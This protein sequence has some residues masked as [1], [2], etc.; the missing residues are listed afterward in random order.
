MTTNYAYDVLD[1]L[2]A[3]CQGGALD[4]NNNCT[5]GQSRQFS[6]DWLKRL[7]SATNP[8]T[9]IST[10]PGGTIQYTQYDGNGNLLAKQDTRMVTT[11]MTYDAM[12]RILTKSY[13]D[14]AT[15][16][17]TYCYDGAVAAAGGGSCTNPQTAIP[18]AL[19]HLTQ[20]YSSASATT[21]NAF[22]GSGRVVL[23]SQQT[24]SVG[25]TLYQFGTSASSNPGYAYNLASQLTTIK[26]PS[27][28]AVAYDYDLAGRTAK[29]RNPVAQGVTY[30]D[31]SLF[32]PVGGQYAYAPHGAIQKMT[33]GSG[34][35]EST[36]WDPVRLQPT[37]VQAGSLLTLQYA[38]CPSGASGCASNNGNLLQQQ[39]TT[40]NLA[41]TQ[42]YQYTDGF[43]QVTSA[44]ETSN[45]TGGTSWSQTYQYDSYGNRAV[46]SGYT[47][48]TILT[49]SA[50]SQYVETIGVSQVNRNHWTGA[51]YDNA[52]NVNAV[53]GS[54][55][56]F[57]Y[58][59][60]N[61]M[62]TS[63]EPNMG[64]ISYVYDGD[65]KR[66]QKTVG[67]AVTSYVYDA[68]EEL[69][70]EY[71]AATDVGTAYLNVDPLGSTRLFLNPAAGETKYFDYF[72]FGEDIQ[73]GI[74]TRGANYPTGAYPGTPDA[75][76]AKF[77]AKE[78]DAETGLDYFGARYFSSAQGRF[79][80][81]DPEIIPNN[82]GNPQAWNKY[83]YTYN[84][85]LRYTDPDGHAP[86][87]GAALIQDRDVKDLL[88]NRITQQEYMDRQNARGAGAIVG[89]G[90][91]ASFFAPQLGE[92]LFGWAI[93][94]PVQVHEAVA[95]VAEGVSDAPPSSMTSSFA[96][97]GATTEES[98][99]RKLSQYLLNPEHP[100]GGSKANWFEQ[101]LGFTKSNM[102]DLAKQIVFD[103]A[104]AVQTGVTQYGTQYNQVITITGANGKKIA[105]TF[106]FIKN[107][108]NVVRLVTAI[109]AKQ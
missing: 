42:N 91:V 75:E 46:T 7:T 67:N 56:S 77:T 3:V 100:V 109:P 51:T 63:T 73:Q 6:Y 81:P 88:A 89:L 43:S 39:I 72:P 50:L 15:P 62:T 2:V 57:T 60:E 93:S 34:I 76:P 90:T 30:A 65:G 61:R 16:P 9:S 31:L 25:G 69:V 24:P 48:Y 54:G 96:R 41:V 49:P 68:R 59:A 14:Q 27:G 84:N 17:V 97:L 29:V 8:E 103:P 37:Q 28:R 74:G 4:S 12:N 26:Y 99:E 10:Q 102:G 64:G 1:D 33:M 106:A 105:T 18:N 19:G 5:S 21:Y 85:P 104:K 45:S 80:S 107:T 71:G 23:S 20:V 55:R 101:A 38:Y 79:T 95:S 47:P 87:E 98:V 94:H 78:R 58:D 86:Q 53:I 92:A 32:N 13:S 35:V 44:Q 66:V 52:G 70:A 11:R 40:P 36:V 82:I 22:D 108:D 83:A